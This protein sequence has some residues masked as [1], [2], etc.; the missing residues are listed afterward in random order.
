LTAEGAATVL[1]AHPD[2]DVRELVA[3]VAEGAGHRVVRL[4]SPAPATVVD[5]SVDSL[6][7]AVIL[8]T[9][10]T[11]LHELT[12][13][14]EAFSTRGYPA[15]V[16]ALVDGEATRDWCL[17]NGVQRVLQRPFHERDLVQA[18][19]MV[20]DPDLAEPDPEPE[21]ATPRVMPIGVGHAFTDILRM[22]RQL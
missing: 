3:R 19:Q 7:L 10:A 13:I 8:D 20:L 9:Q 22:G 4:D 15:G 21:E 14:T 18:I 5:T 11:A 6:A 17:A 12:S 1:V 2:P 16:I